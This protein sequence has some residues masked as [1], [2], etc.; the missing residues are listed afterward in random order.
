MNFMLSNYIYDISCLI[1]TYY[2]SYLHIFKYNWRNL[3]KDP[4][5][6]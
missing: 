2:L 4:I 3:K 5:H 1:I 6:P